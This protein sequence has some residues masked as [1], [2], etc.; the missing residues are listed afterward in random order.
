L[1]PFLQAPESICKGH[2]EILGSFKIESYTAD[3][4]FEF[5]KWAL[6]PFF[7]Y[8]DVTMPRLH[9]CRRAAN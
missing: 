2:V 5:L 8:M 9:G 3:R 4:F 6:C 7:S 1:G